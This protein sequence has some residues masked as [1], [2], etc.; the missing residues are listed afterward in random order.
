V[1]FPVVPQDKAAIRI[2]LRADMETSVIRSFCE[3]I[4]TLLLAHG[5]DIRP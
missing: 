3:Q 4:I 5:R 1:F 2:T